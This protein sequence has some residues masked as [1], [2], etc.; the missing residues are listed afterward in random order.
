MCS[1]LRGLSAAWLGWLV[2]LGP[3]GRPAGAGE[4]LRVATYNVEN[5]GPAGR[6]TEAGYRP[7]YP[8]P[9]P[10]KQALRRV[11]QGLA[12]DV[13]FLQEMGDARYLDELRRD[14][15]AEGS[16]Y[17]FG[18]VAAA[19]DE[20][21]RVAVL[22]RRELRAVRTHDDLGITYF[23]A[24]ETVK[25]GMLEVTVATAAGDVTLFGIH[26]KSRFTD[27]PDDPLSA[28]RRA[29]EA[30]A[31]RDRVLQRFPAPAQARFLVLGDCNDGRSSRA[32]AF[33]QKR[34]RTE[35]AQLLPAADSR[36]ETWSH[37]YRREETYTRVDH[38]FVSPGL[39]AYVR[40]MA[41]GIYDGDGV[42]K[43]SDHRPVFV[44]LDLA[45]R[46]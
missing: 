46:E 21:R 12:A 34:G 43:A 18:A 25:R 7:D 27:R 10:E 14:L 5:Y 1:M 33:L 38:V 23:G 2:T 39:R 22:S 44:V 4:A 30:T 19:A 32:V 17:P 8:K 31:I 42:A 9:E 26:L 6:L 24:K 16:D 3:A 40:G 29:A 41:A 15:R 37:A 13:V 36:G 11:L 35:I 20:D 45:E 28:I